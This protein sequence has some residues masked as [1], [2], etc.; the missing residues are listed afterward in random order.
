MIISIIKGFCVAVIISTIL[1]ANAQAQKV[2]LRAQINPTCTSSQGTAKFSD[3]FADGNI[4]VQGG[5]GCKGVFIYDISNPDAPVLAS[6]Y[7]SATSIQF[8]E[9][10]VVGNRGYFGS[11]NGSGV[12]I[13]DLTNPYA[14][15]LLGTVDSTHGN[16]HNAI[17]EMM[18]IQQNGATYLLENYNSLSIK[19]LRIINV[20]NPATP[21]FKWEFNPSDV[22]W[23]HAMHIRGNRMYTSGWGGKLEIYDISNLAT[24]AP[25]LIGAI[26]GD[27]RN[28]STWTSENGNYLYSCRET[29]DGD[30]RVYDVSNPAVPFLVRSIKTSDLGLNAV[31]PHNPVVV[32]NL[33][34]VAW[35][36]A[37]MQ[38]FDITDPTFP[39]RVGQYDTYQPAFAPPA[40]TAKSENK[41]D[42]KLPVDAEPWDIVCGREN[43]QNALPTSYDGN[44]A[45]HPF[46]GQDK[47]L[48]GDLTYGL[49][50]L[51]ATNV[52]SI[53]KNRVS[54]FDGDKRTD[55]SVF[56]PSIGAWQIERSSDGLAPRIKTRQVQSG[57]IMVPGDYDGDGISE[58]GTFR[59]STAH[60]FIKN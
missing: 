6:W 58:I 49:I 10:I 17:H 35:Y 14:P 46:L 18:V 11:G 26:Q 19:P 4:A 40:E 34:Y 7:S 43:L 51:D 3:I 21:V 54:D 23:V 31:S 9:A 24:Q 20:T 39:K 47:I 2:R 53:L 37:G 45:V 28:H 25:T 33:L 27:T 5:Y 55:F 38:V 16:G 44:W 29:N 41:S 60:W 15:V 36:Q 56:R 52:L 48:A 32:G 12:H 22:S 57:D 42:K 30:L 1:I 13:V 50:V 59:P 8:L